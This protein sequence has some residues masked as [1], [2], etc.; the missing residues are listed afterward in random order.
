MIAIKS[1]H[2]I[3]KMKVAGRIAGAA[4][5]EAGRAVRPGITT[6]E[7]DEIVR[8]CIEAEGATPTFLGYGGFPASACVS[9]NEQVIHGIPSRKT[10]LREGD[11]FH[12]C[13]GCPKSVTNTGTI[14]TK[15]LVT[16]LPPQA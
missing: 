9:V 15:M 10:V 12:C 6:A 14:V 1:L 4:L 7:L 3:E 16:L 13:G 2:E 8:S 11:S 5:R